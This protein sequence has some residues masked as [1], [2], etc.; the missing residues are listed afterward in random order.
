MTYTTTTLIFGFAVAVHYGVFGQKDF[1]TGV[2]GGPQGGG[3]LEEIGQVVIKTKLGQLRGLEVAVHP[4]FVHT[5]LMNAEPPKTAHAFL[6][7]NY[8]EP[9]PRFAVSPL[10]VHIYGIWG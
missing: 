9:V 7:V 6:N 8:S 10:L 2:I 1:Y 5:E 4:M 3:P